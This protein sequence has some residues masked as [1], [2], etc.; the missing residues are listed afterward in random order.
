MA[1]RLDLKGFLKKFPVL[2]KITIK[3]GDLDAYQHVNNCMYFKYQE[4]ARLRYFG[5]I[6]KHIDNKEFDVEKFSI[7]TGIGPIM[8]DT[9]CS[10]K[11]PLTVPDKILVGSTILP[12]DLSKGR[13][14]LSHSVWSL[15]H[16]RV[17]ADGFGTVVSYDFQNAKACD[18][19][20]VMVR[21][22]EKVQSGDSLHLHD[23]IIAHKE[24]L[25]DEF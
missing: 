24:D 7:G 1:S 16:N 23:N 13:Y 22:I 21:A 18:I 2:S 12:G 11:L 5:H 3:W 19:P 10:F 17:V 9:Y 4:V 14:K 6:L 8:S 15:R 20:A 25:E